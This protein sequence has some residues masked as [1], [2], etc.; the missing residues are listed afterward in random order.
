[1]LQ[2]LADRYHISVSQQ[3]RSPDEDRPAGVYGEYQDG[4]Q[5]VRLLMPLTMMNEAGE[6][7]KAMSVNLAD[8]LLV[9][10]DVNLP[11]GALRLRPQGSAGGHHG[12]ESCLSVLGTEQVARLRI[13]VGAA[14][15]PRD[16]REYVLSP[17]SESE[18]PIFQ[19][20]LEQ[21][22]DACQTWVTEGL[23]MAMNRYNSA[24][25]VTP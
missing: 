3:V 12:L 20:A 19:Q 21:A 8:L 22:A 10:D 7:L 4:T 16:L 17:V 14:Q 11:L 15:L 25:D 13:G 24:Q 9:C 2:L 5:T 18:R 23:D 1:V 6:V